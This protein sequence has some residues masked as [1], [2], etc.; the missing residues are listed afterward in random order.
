MN[1]KELIGL[2]IEDI[3]VWSQ[4]DVVGLDEAEVFIKL[5]NDKVV[6]IPWDFESEE[7]EK[8]VRK[9]SFSIVKKA[10]SLIKF[11]SEKYNLPEGKTYRDIMNEINEKQKSSFFGRLKLFFGIKDAIP[12][13]YVIRKTYYEENPFGK[14]KDLMIVDFLMFDEYDSVGFLELEDGSV[15][16]EI[17]TAP[18]GTGMAGLSYFENLE[19]FE[20]RCGA[21]YNRLTL[22]LKLQ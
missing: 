6:G 16:S 11:R 9:G 14:I 1:T 20:D 19:E 13:Q 18:H 12:K 17:A 7:I 4:M 3:L 8:E 5:K 15:I 10:S 22:T 21:N 2:K